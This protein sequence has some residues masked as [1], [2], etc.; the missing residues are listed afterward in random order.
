M[1]HRDSPYLIQ[2]FTA[3]LKTQM[4]KADT[5]AVSKDG[6]PV[7]TEIRVLVPRGAMDYR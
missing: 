3:G 7:P 6:L 5:L 2:Q 1:H 4:L